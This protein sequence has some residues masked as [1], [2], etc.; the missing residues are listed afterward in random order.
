MQFYMQIKWIYSHNIANIVSCIFS[1]VILLLLLI[2]K[3]EYQ[4][5]IKQVKKEEQNPLET[6]QQRNVKSFL[7][8]FACVVSL[9]VV[10]SWCCVTL[11][12]ILAQKI[13]LCLHY[14][15]FLPPC[16]KPWM[17]FET[18]KLFFKLIAFVINININNTSYSRHKHKY[19]KNLLR[20]DI[21]A[22]TLQTT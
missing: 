5:K 17:R 7:C 9:S 19:N 18:C 16:L 3:R 8:C 10:L 13:F 20:K 12:Y 15:Y 11:L 4:I 21:P 6:K 2:T 14:V 22:Y 1:A